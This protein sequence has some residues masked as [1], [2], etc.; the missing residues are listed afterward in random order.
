M[1][2]TKHT[3]CFSQSKLSII[4]HVI[5][6][7]H[8]AFMPGLSACQVDKFGVINL[9]RRTYAEEWLVW[10]QAPTHASVECSTRALFANCI[11]RQC[12]AAGSMMDCG[13]TLE[14][15]APKSTR[16]RCLFGSVRASVIDALGWSAG[17]LLLP[18]FVTAVKQTRHLFGGRHYIW[19][20]R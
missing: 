15:L 7:F 19:N 17:R 13:E 4:M 11:A 18:L 20:L 8:N 9:A 1:D 14:G 16:C 10:D 2:C 5:K 3:I 12:L 6:D